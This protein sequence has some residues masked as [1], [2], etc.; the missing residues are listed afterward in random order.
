[1]AKTYGHLQVIDFDR[2]RPPPKMRAYFGDSFTRPQIHTL[3][4]SYKT[5]AAMDVNND[6]RFPRLHLG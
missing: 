4:L 3:N 6:T 2:L 5:M 1:H